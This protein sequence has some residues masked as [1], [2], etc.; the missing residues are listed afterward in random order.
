MTAPAPRMPQLPEEQE[1]RAVDMRPEQES[2]EEAPATPR[3]GRAVINIAKPTARVDPNR[4][5][6]L[7]LFLL[8]FLTLISGLAR[9]L[10]VT[11]LWFA[12]VRPSLLVLMYI[13]GL[14]Q[15]VAAIV[16]FVSGS[17]GGLGVLLA[18]FLTAMIA[19]VQF[20][21]MMIPAFAYT[22]KPHAW[23]LGVQGGVILLH[24]AVLAA[25]YFNMHMIFV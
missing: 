24:A 23:L 9:A 18:A 11:P 17:D 12:L 16:M 1:G 20:G 3:P 10:D 21:L 5:R 14:G 2:S 6:F 13:P 15:G 4:L 25:F 7:L 8:L 22:W 19:F